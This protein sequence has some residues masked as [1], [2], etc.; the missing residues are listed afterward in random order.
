MRRRVIEKRAHPAKDVLE[1]IELTL[2]PVNVNL[3]D[4]PSPFSPHVFRHAFDPSPFMPV[5]SRRVFQ[6]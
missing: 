6:P 4:L 2:S 3:P 1:H 5:W